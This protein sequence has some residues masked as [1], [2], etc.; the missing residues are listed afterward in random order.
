MFKICAYEV[1]DAAQQ[2]E[3]AISAAI[4]D[5]N[6]WKHNEKENLRPILEILF[7]AFEARQNF[8]ELSYK[9]N[10]ERKEVREY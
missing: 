3:I 7:D 4:R 1:D 5:L 8:N 10:K 6:D 9:Y 2:Y